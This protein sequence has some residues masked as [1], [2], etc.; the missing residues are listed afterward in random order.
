MK[1]TPS[2]LTRGY[3]F[4]LLAALILSTTAIFIRHLTQTYGLPPLVLAFWR[5]VFVV[6]TLLPALAL[7]KP[8]LLRVQGEHIR[9]LAGY[10]LVL[11]FFNALWTLSVALNGA[12]VATVLVYCSAAFTAL[13]GWRLLGERL[14]WGKII[15]VLFSLGGCVLVAGAYDPAIWRANLGGILAG[16]LSGLGYAVYSLMGRSAAQRGL[17]PWT[18]LLYTFGFAGLFLLVIN[19]LPGTILPVG[20]FST[21]VAA[22]PLDLWWLG[23]AVGG[24]VV[25][26]LLAAGPTVLGFGT[27]NVSLSLLPSSIANLIVTL[28]PAFTALIAFIL[29]GERLTAAQIAG[30]LVILAGVVILRLYEDPP[31]WLDRRLVRGQS[32]K[33]PSAALRKSPAQADD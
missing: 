19:L 32:P 9:Y 25:L 16:V 30:S 15:A 27:Y 4:A 21:A 28:E 1:P 23:D 26:F 18:T 3:I 17:N 14:G 2:T 31:A 5:D 29:L 33:S 22:Q 13:L 8:G 20:A 11:A 12:A 10:G 7:L 24:W 6:L